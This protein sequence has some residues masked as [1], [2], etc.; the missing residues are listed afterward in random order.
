MENNIIENLEISE[1]QNL[2]TPW[3]FVLS[4]VFAA[5]VSTAI[6]YLAEPY[7]EQYLLI[8][9][10]AVVIALTQALVLRN[11]F[12]NLIFWVLLT[13]LAYLAMGLIIFLLRSELTSFYTSISKTSTYVFLFGFDMLVQAIIASV[14]YLSLKKE[15]AFASRWIVISVFS[16]F[17]GL[18]A[19]ILIVN[20]IVT[21]GSPA[22]FGSYLRLIN[23]SINSLVS[24]LISGIGM[25][26]LLEN[27]IFSNE[28]LVE[29]LEN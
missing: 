17:L 16:V 27:K 7:F 2:I 22:T 12:K 20:L 6:T 9:I 1:E 18:M 25:V 26:Y 8:V 11:Y 28:M 29:E 5:L 13:F 3:K 15:V 19:Q 4:W 14:Q 23:I 10:K 21:F 24:Y